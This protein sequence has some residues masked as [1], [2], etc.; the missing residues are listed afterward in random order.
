MNHRLYVESTCE[1]LLYATGLFIFMFY[2]LGCYLSVPMSLGT[3]LN[4][5]L[6]IL[7]VDASF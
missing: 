2:T 3:G 6:D 1:N 5:L 4:P 7:T